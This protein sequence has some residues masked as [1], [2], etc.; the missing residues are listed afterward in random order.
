MHEPSATDDFL[1]DLTVMDPVLAQI[2]DRNFW[3]NGARSIAELGEIGFKTDRRLDFGGV[4]SLSKQ[5]LVRDRFVRE[6]SFA[7]PCEE[8]VSLIARRSPEI[9]EL[10]AGTGFWA[11]L[12]AMAGVSIVATDSEPRQAFDVA[13]EGLDAVDA[14]KAYP[15]RDV[16]CVWPSLGESWATRAAQAMAPGRTLYYVGEW[17]GCTADESFHEYLEDAFDEVML[18]AIPVFVGVHDNLMIYRKRAIPA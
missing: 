14:V 3:I 18:V 10:G 11:H 8:A 1:R 5:W 16:L 17:C 15:D 13:Y 9:I 6:Y 12:L 7:I 2:L 4:S